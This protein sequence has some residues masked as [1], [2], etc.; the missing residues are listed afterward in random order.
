[1][2]VKYFEPIAMMYGPHITPRVSF[3]I[4]VMGW[5]PGPGL[6][7]E[8]ERN[9]KPP[10]LKGVGSCGG[11]RRSVTSFLTLKIKFS[12]VICFLFNA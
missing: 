6:N 3:G 8:R 2:D 12:V 4:G 9:T 5:R 11:G 10:A 7:P 1:M